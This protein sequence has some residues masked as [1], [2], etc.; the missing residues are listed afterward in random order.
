[1][2]IARVRQELPKLAPESS[3]SL[4]GICNIFSLPC[5]CAARVR[6]L[7]RAEMLGDN[8]GVF[9]NTLRILEIPFNFTSSLCNAIDLIFKGLLYFGLTKS[10]PFLKV[11]SKGMPIVGL[12]VGGFETFFEIRSFKQAWEMLKTVK[13]PSSEA[14]EQF[15]VEFCQNPQTVNQITTF[16]R[17]TFAQSSFEEQ[18]RCI[19]DYVQYTNAARWRRLERRV[20][21]DC[22]ERFYQMIFKPNLTTEQ[23][24]ELVDDIQAQLQKKLLLH[25]IGLISC[26]LAIAG[27]ITMLY[28]CPFMIPL[29]LVSI[30]SGLSIIRWIFAEGI[31]PCKGWHF[32][33]AY[34]I[35]DC[36]RGLF[37]KIFKP[38]DAAL[39]SLQGRVQTAP[40]LQNTP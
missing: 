22:A 2:D 38:N 12:I 21:F 13:K 4:P 36:L 7:Y 16:V 5:T 11:M 18:Q 35:P 20:G 3:P 30:S 32:E 6:D 28:G 27:V 9:E 25:A 39:L 23:T 15:R 34:L 19:A 37:R 40:A 10:T 29:I 31:L 8:E 24:Q 14:L 26:L 33:P 1:M 17:S